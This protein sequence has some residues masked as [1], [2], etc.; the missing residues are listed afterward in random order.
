[1][2]IRFSVHT[3][4]GEVGDDLF[5]VTRV[6]DVSEPLFVRDRDSL[7]F[8]L[9]REDL[10]QVGA[11]QRDGRLAVLLAAVVNSRKDS[12]GFTSKAGLESNRAARLHFFSQ[13]K[14]AQ[15]VHAVGRKAEPSSDSLRVRIGRAN[16]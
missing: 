14:L 12:S 2:R 3:A 16:G 1:M 9:L 7:P 10:E 4:V 13:A 15:H 11:S 6:A 5:M 8:H